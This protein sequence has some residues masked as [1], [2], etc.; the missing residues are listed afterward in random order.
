VERCDHGILVVLASRLLSNPLVEFASAKEVH[1]QSSA[2]EIL[3]RLKSGHNRVDFFTIVIETLS[4]MTIDIFDTN[5]WRLEGWKGEPMVDTAEFDGRAGKAQLVLL[6]CDTKWANMM[7]RTLL[8]GI[9]ILAI[10]DVT[11]RCNTSILEDE[12]LAERI[13]LLPVRCGNGET[14][15]S[16]HLQTCFTLNVMSPWDALKTI[17]PVASGAMESTCEDVHVAFSQ[18]GRDKGFVIS[19]IAPEQGIDI[20]AQVNAGTPAMHARFACISTIGFRQVGSDYKL[21]MRMVGQLRPSVAVNEAFRVV[22]ECIAELRSVLIR[23]SR[24]E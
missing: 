14:L 5:S 10:N 9:R 7:R 11:L 23:L 12:V 18:D 16:H 17:T 6:G 1:P 2:T 20:V 15:K 24:Y 8:G 3:V 4:G 13:R 21:S 19:L 22:A